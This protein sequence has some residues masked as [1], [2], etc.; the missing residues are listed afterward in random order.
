ME[1]DAY[2]EKW[3]KLVADAM[4]EPH[5]ESDRLVFVVRGMGASL[6]PT[7]KNDCSYEGSDAARAKEVYFKAR[8]CAR[9][10]VRTEWERK[11]KVFPWDAQAEF[12]PETGNS[13]KATRGH[14]EIRVKSYGT[15]YG[16]KRRIS[17]EIEAAERLHAALGD[18]IAYARAG[19]ISEPKQ[20]ED[21]AAYVG[22]IVAARD[23]GT[24]AHIGQDMVK[25]EWQKARPGTYARA[26][27]EEYLGSGAFKLVRGL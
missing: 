1:P 24:I 5:L 16:Y 23:T 7:E 13:I 25:I 19:R 11:P 12:D 6:E 27:F 9:V 22:A 21:F 2:A 20:S 18:A 8:L 3:D 10:H 14:L 4:A 26:E 15:S 17:L